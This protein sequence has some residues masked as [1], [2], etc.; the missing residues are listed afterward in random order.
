[1][2][3]QL[4][5]R[6][7]S[8]SVVRHIVAQRR[9][10]EAERQR[11]AAAAGH[12]T[13]ARGLLGP[14]A[15]SAG[16]GGS[17]GG[18]S[19]AAGAAEPPVSGVILVADISGFSSLCEKAGR[20]ETLQEELCRV[21]NG[22][23]SKEVELAERYGGKSSAFSATLPSA[24][25]S[26]AMALRAAKAV[27]CGLA[28]Q[29]EFSSVCVGMGKDMGLRVAVAAGDFTEY[30]C[31]LGAWS[32]GG[33]EPA[34]VD[35]RGHL[36]PG[37]MQHFIAGPAIEEAG[38]AL[39]AVKAG[40]V[41][42][43]RSA[44]RY[45]PA[46]I[47]AASAALTGGGAGGGR[48]SSRSGRSGSRRGSFS[49]SR[50][51]GGD[52]YDSG[53]ESSP[54][55]GP[56]SPPGSRGR[57]SGIFASPS[58]A[59][60]H[61]VAYPATRDA[62]EE[63]VAGFEPRRPAEV[64]PL[65]LE[66]EEEDE[67]AL[68][69][70]YTVRARFES[71]RA[72]AASGSNEAFDPTRFL[73]EFRLCSVLFLK[74]CGLDPSHESVQRAVRSLQA[75]LYSHEG[76][77]RQV[78]LDDKGMVFIGVF[79]LWPF[80]HE[81]DALR[82]VGCAV[83]MQESMRAMGVDT[84]VG[85]TSGLVFC[86]FVGSPTRCEFSVFGQTVNRAARLM[87]KSENDV[88]VDAKTHEACRSKVRM[89]HVGDFNLK[90][91][92]GKVPVY[93]PERRGGAIRTTSFRH[94]NKSFSRKRALASVTARS[95]EEARVDA[96]V[97]AASAGGLLAAPAAP[98]AAPEPSPGGA[99]A[100][101]A[102]WEPP[103]PSILL[104]EGPS[105][106]GKSVLAAH[107]ARVAA[108][109]D[110]V[111]VHSAAR[112]N[113][114]TSALFVWRAIVRALFPLASL[115][116]GPLLD[117][118][119]DVEL[120]AHL[121][122]ALHAPEREP[123]Y[124]AQQ[125]QQASGGRRRKAS[126]SGPD[127]VGGGKGR[128]GSAGVMWVQPDAFTVAAPAAGPGPGPGPGPPS[129]GST[130]PTSMPDMV[131]PQEAGTVFV[132]A[133]RGSA[134]DREHRLTSASPE[135]NPFTGG[136][137]R[138]RTAAR[139]PRSRSTASSPV[140]PDAFLAQPSLPGA[141]DEPAAS[142]A[143]GAPRMS[144]LMALP[145]VH[146]EAGP[147]RRHSVHDRAAE[148]AGGGGG[149][150]DGGGGGGLTDSL[151]PEGDGYVAGA[152]AA[153]SDGA[154]PPQSDTSLKG[155]RAP[156]LGDAG[157]RS[158]SKLLSFS[159]RQGG[160]G[161]AA[162]A[163]ATPK[164]GA[165][166]PH[167][168]GGRLRRQQSFEE[169][170]EEGAAPAAI[171][172][173]PTAPDESVE[174]IAC[175]VRALVAK[176]VVRR[177]AAGRPILV[178]LEDLHHADSQSWAVLGE[179]IQALAEAPAGAARVALVGT[180]RTPAEHSPAARAA[181]RLQA[182]HRGRAELI[183]LGPLTDGDVE[184]LVCSTV[185][186]ARVPRA[187]R[188][189]VKAQ[190][191]G[192]AV[193]VVDLARSLLQEG[194]LA[195]D[196]A[197]DAIVK[198]PLR[199]LKPTDGA[200]AAVMEKLDRLTAVQSTT[201]KL[202]AVIG[203]RFSV[204]EL[205]AIHPG[206]RSIGGGGSSALVSPQSPEAEP[207]VEQVRA[208]VAAASRDA[209]LGAAIDREL[210]ALVK[211]GILKIDRIQPGR[212]GLTGA[213]A[214]GEADA[215]EEEGGGLV[216]AADAL[217][218]ASGAP[219]EYEF[220]QPLT[221]EVVYSLLPVTERRALHLKLALFH[222]SRLRPSPSTLS[223]GTL[224]P[225]SSTLSPSPILA[226]APLDERDGPG[227]VDDDLAAT[228]AHHFVL[229]NLNGRAGAQ[230]PGRACRYLERCAEAAYAS[231]ANFEAMRLYEDLLQVSAAAP[232]RPATRL[233]WMRQLATVYARLDMFKESIAISLAALEAAGR[234]APRSPLAQ[235]LSA[236]W[237]TAKVLLKGA[238][239]PDRYL[240]GA[241]RE[242][243]GGGEAAEM[244]QEL[245]R[246]YSVLLFTTYGAE[247]GVV[248]SSYCISTA[249]EKLARAKPPLTP[250]RAQLAARA[251]AQ[252]PP[253]LSGHTAIGLAR[254]A[255]LCGFAG[256]RK[257]A[258]Q[259]A[260][261]AWS[262]A[263][264]IASPEVWHDMTNPLAQTLLAACAFESASSALQFLAEE[265]ERARNLN[266]SALVCT[267][268]GVLALRAS[269]RL[270]HPAGGVAG[271]AS[272]LRCA[273]SAVKR[274]P[275]ILESFYTTV[276]T[277]VLAQCSLLMDEAGFGLSVLEAHLAGL[278][279]GVRVSLPFRASLQGILAALRAALFRC[280]G[281]EG[282]GAD[283]RTAARVACDAVDL[284]RVRPSDRGSFLEAREIPD[285]VELVSRLGVYADF[286]FE[287]TAVLYYALLHT[288]RCRPSP[289][290]RRPSSRT[291]R[292]T[293]AGARD[294][295][296]GPHRHRL[297]AAAEPLEHAGAAAAA[298]PGPGELLAAIEGADAYMK[299]AG[300]AR[301][302]ARAAREGGQLCDEGLALLLQAAH[303]PAVPDRARLAAAAATLFAAAGDAFHARV[304]RAVAAAAVA[305]P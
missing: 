45:L 233:R 35:A 181:A 243:E 259:W 64:A 27:A 151:M 108:Q 152:E 191:D 245:S 301:L 289:G 252:D 6:F 239:R 23:F 164:G 142:A 107:A 299:R 71:M 186:A 85:I 129:K 9:A 187:L 256:H 73:S 61:F 82:A 109:L 303:A 114:E 188:D 41:A 282:R 5:R 284:S 25:A 8:S 241:R 199:R 43:C 34:L 231:F 238:P 283:G 12:A 214:Q 211:L 119:T 144:K 302:A 69:V 204:A 244:S 251:V 240:R 165:A 17:A 250:A 150:G 175:G 127:G 60:S 75:V 235:R 161:A 272:E 77:L 180:L 21:I 226:G 101:R 254:A 123:Q 49:G 215:G 7:V 133:R 253:T 260:S 192:L 185:G 2:E 224:S 153:P 158:S 1:M 200:R 262:M 202:A 296:D 154:P 18:R 156:K 117:V 104:F 83:D 138:P 31:G 94:S 179:L 249:R 86:T 70:P 53:A 182:E 160:G 103:P 292:R 277:A 89:A 203:V 159:W 68:Y 22:A 115:D 184:A 229:A 274:N 297:A 263:L 197:G 106:S 50:G 173:Q 136:P 135:P 195:V 278:V 14:A 113:R 57:L 111:V 102:A 98:A 294:G 96:V 221:Q 266:H 273:L 222:E 242:P 267:W 44:Q 13:S 149:G 62:L 194:A 100:S 38:A 176:L 15:A 132:L 59:E 32:G 217:S 26:A 300:K 255:Q 290:R 167:S 174:W 166:T 225:A 172:A 155:R 140:P 124:N 84:S 141:P 261:L 126:A 88:Y 304:A 79:G 78:V 264:E 213:G 11:N 183:K 55:R 157:E 216:E 130:P 219:R 268:R 72:W 288:G 201:L 280:A 58:A 210:A 227:G 246:L 205:L 168:A 116:M 54:E 163:A 76:S 247:H 298:P 270:A 99:S 122:K 47:V 170:F 218:A 228:L 90:G 305:P 207:T 206:S 93:R 37:R 189:F 16:A 67:I 209:S 74:L 40:E 286:F 10:R 112:E 287:A 236:Y 237:G 110:M 169:E 190:T 295:A 178:V 65:E 125:Q 33:G 291:S 281:P 63:F 92:E 97:R 145:M 81:N 257:R 66:P 118:E 265:A 42:V 143:A 20:D 220:L 36:V 24:A 271:L 193:L 248:L 87:S 293:G 48:L 223:P 30:H 148:A 230:E 269:A 171:F 29:E 212:A 131:P 147:G 46:A 105:G 120:L 4:A 19:T 39:A 139:D 3:L 177:A 196:T 91:V 28:I 51:Q 80:A 285:G 137:S 234:P 134:A 162:T 95:A 198:G 232:P 128:R 208:A 275:D 121:I 56:F 146:H 258:V 279:S 52:A 276:A